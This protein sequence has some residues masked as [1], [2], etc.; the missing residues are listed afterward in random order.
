M[1]PY[2]P[3][4]VVSYQPACSCFPLSVC[5][6]LCVCSVPQSRPS[7]WDPMDYSTPGSSVHGILQ[8]RLLESDVIYFSWDLPAQKLNL[9]R[10]CLLHFRWIIC[11]YTCEAPC[12]TIDPCY[13]PD[14]WF[15]STWPLP[16]HL[17]SSYLPAVNN[18]V[19]MFIWIFYYFQWTAQF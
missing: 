12:L 8:V 16:Q 17:I 10:L 13:L 6:C 5:V 2:N 14:V 9:Y 19:I 15:P 18:C 4:C 7:L 11:H 3:K 1:D